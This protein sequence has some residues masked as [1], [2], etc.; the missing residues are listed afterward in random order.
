M[1]EAHDLR[2]QFGAV[3]AVDGLSFA[4]REGAITTLLGGNGSGKTTTLRMIGGLI[5]PAS[6]RVEI[7]GV[8]VRRH[9]TKALARLGMLH[10][11][12]GLYPRLTVEEH[13]RFAAEL[14]G[15][16]GRKLSAAVGRVLDELDFGDLRGRL[17]AGLSHG[18]RMKVALARTIVHRPRNLVFDEP[19]RGLDVFSVRVLRDLLM[20]LRAEGACILMS[21]HAMGEV[22]ELSDR[23]VV[24]H[25]GRVL[26]EGSP[27]EI[28]ARAGAKDLESAFVTL[29]SRGEA[30]A[31]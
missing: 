12:F 23:L 6:G 24:I 13:V 1:I 29:T 31:A 15:L 11:E 14:H 4:A 28:I 27:M 20:R 10:D 26:A 17:A 2:K 30:L 19:T 7:D 3:K 25:R 5:T 8:D 16:F 18:Q 9:R 22:M 21:S